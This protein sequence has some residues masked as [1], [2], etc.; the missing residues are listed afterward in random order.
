MILSPMEWFKG[1]LKNKSDGQY[2]ISN[3][4]PLRPID[5]DKNNIV[6]DD[7]HEYDSIYFKTS[8]FG[9]LLILFS[10]II[11]IFIERVKYFE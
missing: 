4:Y 1:Y 8:H 7:S 5:V 9:C 3:V 6:N 11:S 10:V 2:N